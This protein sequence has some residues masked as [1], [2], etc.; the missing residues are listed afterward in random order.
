MSTIGHPLSDLIN[1]TQ[2]YMTA[3]EDV[4]SN[5]S[6][7]PGATPGLPTKEQVIAWYAEIAGW[8]PEPELDWGSAFGLY[9][10]SVI[11]QGVAARYALKQTSSEKA[12]YYADMMVPLG[13]VAYKM[14]LKAKRARSKQT[15]L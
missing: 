9:R 15:K 4:I 12:K 7:L 10:N 3:Q 8:D 14:F 5:K 11:A 6:F 13:E 2:P 1:L